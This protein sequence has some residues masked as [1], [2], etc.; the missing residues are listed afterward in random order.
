[1]VLA[2]KLWAKEHSINEARFQTLSSYAL[3]LMV[4]HYLQS[5]VFPPV[6]PCLQE[7]L[8][9]VF[10]SDSMIFDLP[11]TPPPWVSRNRQSLGEL[12]SGFFSYYGGG[13]RNFDPNRDVASVRKGMV[14]EQKDCEAYARMHK[15][16]PGQWNA[17]I[18]IEEPFDRTNAARAVCS[19]Q[20]WGLIVEAF[21]YTRDV[22]ERGGPNL[23]LEDLRPRRQHRR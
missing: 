22:V 15:L 2:V 4:L 14:L 11:Y 6:L 20:K 13:P 16:S 8:P 5:G 12:L 10:N 9:N 23:G 19:D 3:T 7:E 21:L 1:M 18:L 17:R